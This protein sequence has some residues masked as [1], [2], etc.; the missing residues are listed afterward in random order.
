LGSYVRDGLTM[1]QSSG[2]EAVERARVVD[3]KF[4][5]DESSKITAQRTVV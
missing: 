1:S 2:G 3:E 5:E 4:S